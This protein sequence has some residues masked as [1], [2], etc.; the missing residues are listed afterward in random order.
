MEQSHKKS[1]LRNYNID[2]LYRGLKEENKKLHLQF[3]DQEMLFESEKQLQI[4][5][6]QMNDKLLTENA[7]LSSS[8]TEMRQKVRRMP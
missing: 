6:K 3:K 5:L 1:R 4:S 7:E 8:L 2:F